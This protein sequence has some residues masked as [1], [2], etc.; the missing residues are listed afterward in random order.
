[1]GGI[2]VAQLLIIGVICVLVFGT[3]KLRT[4][5]SDL[6]YALKSFQKAMRDEPETTQAT[7]VKNE[8]TVQTQTRVENKID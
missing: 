2:S 5:G 7:T 1:M 8:E 3:K 4:V 6:G